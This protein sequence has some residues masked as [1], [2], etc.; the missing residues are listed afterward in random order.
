MAFAPPIFPTLPSYGHRQIRVRLTGSDVPEPLERAHP[1]SRLR[2]KRGPCANTLTHTFRPFN[3]IAWPAIGPLWVHKNSLSSHHPS[4]DTDV[5]DE[6]LIQPHGWEGTLRPRHWRPDVFGRATIVFSCVPR[7]QHTNRHIC[8]D[9]TEQLSNGWVDRSNGRD[10]LAHWSCAR[11]QNSVYAR[12]KGDSKV[13]LVGCGATCEGFVVGQGE[14]D[15]VC[16]PQ[17]KHPSAV[18]FAG[19]VTKQSHWAG[20]RCCCH[21]SSVQPPVRPPTS[22]FEHKASSG[23]LVAYAATSSRWYVSPQRWVDAQQ[24]NSSRYSMGRRGTLRARSKSVVNAVVDSGVPVLALGAMAPLTSHWEGGP[25]SRLTLAIVASRTRPRWSDASKIVRLALLVRWLTPPNPN[26][27]WAPDKGSTI[28]TDQS[29]GGLQWA[30][31]EANG[32]FDRFLGGHTIS[33]VDVMRC[34]SMQFASSSRCHLLL[35]CTAPVLTATQAVLLICG[36]LMTLGEVSAGESP[37]DAL[38]TTLPAQA[39]TSRGQSSLERTRN[40][41]DDE[42]ELMLPEN[43]ETLTSRGMHGDCPCRRTPPAADHHPSTNLAGDQRR[44]RWPIR[45]KRRPL[46]AAPTTVTL[47]QRWAVIAERVFRHLHSRV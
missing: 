15:R 46:T 11:I 23:S 25:A 32:D 1:A 45:I 19:V 13:G 7:Q 17:S 5:R 2:E 33:E 37:A 40:A 26:K 27:L 41:A 9:R 10:S 36:E 18:Y 12:T 21:S 34:F 3:R 43:R 28:D 47:P 44:R 24:A 22:P 20:G 16:L 31:L 4:A 30:L 29:G 35:S 6:S 42:T 14:Q 38:L 39:H 8:V